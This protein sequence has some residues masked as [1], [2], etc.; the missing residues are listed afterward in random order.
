M[1]NLDYLYNPD[2][3]KKALNR[4]YF[5]DKKLGFQVIENG[6]ILPYKDVIVDGKRR[7]WGYGGIVD[8]NGEYIKSSHVRGD[9]GA[10]YTPPPRINSTQI[11]NRYLYGHVFSC[12]GAHYNR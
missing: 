8:S 4:N 12:V 9:L 6:T 5:S 2:A 10:S 7:V 11:W 3:A 1:V